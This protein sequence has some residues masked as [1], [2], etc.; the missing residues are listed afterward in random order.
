[1]LSKPPVREEVLQVLHYLVPHLQSSSTPQ[2]YLFINIW[3]CTIYVHSYICFEYFMFLSSSELFITHSDSFDNSSLL[4]CLSIHN[5]ALCNNCDQN[6][7]SAKTNKNFY[8]YIVFYVFLCLFCFLL[9]PVMMIHQL[10]F[11]CF[12]KTLKLK[13]DGID[14]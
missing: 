9:P 6:F 3:N 13:K 1:M 5:K 8:L 7:K 11:P 2:L 14:K 10:W 4:G 12:Q